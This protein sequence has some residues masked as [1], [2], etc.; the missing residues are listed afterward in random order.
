MAAEET[1]CE[2]YAKLHLTIKGAAE[3]DTTMNNEMFD[4]LSP[5]ALVE[6]DGV[7]KG[8]TPHVFKSAA[9][10]WDHKFPD[11]FDLYHP[12][13]ILTLKVYDFDSP[14][15]FA[16]TGLVQDD[17]IGFLDIRIG[18]IPLNDTI[19][20][21]LQLDHPDDCNDSIVLRR[22]NKDSNEKPT[23]WIEIVMK[24][25][26]KS[27]LDEMFAYML[28]PPYLGPGN[29]LN[30]P[31][32]LIN[33]QEMKESKLKI[34]R[35]LE[36]LI[37]IKE[38]PS[39][40]ILVT[41]CALWF[42]RWWVWHCYVVSVVAAAGVFL[43]T[44]KVEVNEE[45]MDT[46][47]DKPLQKQFLENLTAPL[48]ATLPQNLQNSL[49]KGQRNLER[50][51]E[52]YGKVIKLLEHVFFRVSLPVIG[53]YL[54]FALFW[55]EIL[56]YG[57]FLAKIVGTVVLIY[58]SIVGRVTKGVFLYC[59]HYPIRF[60]QKSP[61]FKKVLNMMGRT[62]TVHSSASSGTERETLVRA[63]S[64]GIV[65]EY[66]GRT[67]AQLLVD[68]HFN[69]LLDVNT[70]KRRLAH[71]LEPQTFNQ[72]RW[73]IMCAGFLWG[74]AMNYECQNCNQAV[75]GNA[76]C[77]DLAQRL[78]NCEGTPQPVPPICHTA[79]FAQTMATV[80]DLGGQTM[81]T[82]QDLGGQVQSLVAPNLRSAASE[83]ADV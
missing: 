42:P 72:P 24:L 21:W 69:N 73:C 40:P 49:R 53:I 75:C 83:Q 81:V 16:Q 62:A 48:H 17:F 13:S 61:N 63:D 56:Q 46:I 54:T 15:M 58:L 26:V 37:I 45:G 68:G 32:L 29:E 65:H 76:R 12:Q 71:V 34:L 19:Q 14:Q 66:G 31:Q 47:K 20:V 57:P 6:V 74:C 38:H 28:F 30:L 10:Q 3:L 82:V 11:P 9:P 23:G 8:R 22:Q 70:S 4:F 41:L 51:N 25:E 2:P 52:A 33:T 79:A 77:R 55:E 50:V 1:H 43:D 67:A 80:Q 5:Y 60:R 18:R 39:L 7:E 78:Y 36:P 59:T 35:I 64:S 27:E 44:M